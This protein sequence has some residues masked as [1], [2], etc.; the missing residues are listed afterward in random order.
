MK[1]QVRIIRLK[2]I[3]IIVS[4]EVFELFPLEQG[5]MQKYAASVLKS[6]GI[7]QY[8]VNI[9]LINDEKITG[10]NEKFKNRKSSTDVLSFNLSDESS[11]FVEGEVYISLERA[12]EQSLDYNVSYEEEIIRLVTHGLLHLAGRTHDSEEEYQS[13]TEDTER[14]VNDFYYGGEIN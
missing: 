9:V 10:L 12:K 8:N 4:D 5:H 6:S 14:F 11:D 1:L 2:K 7:S 3:E 13:M